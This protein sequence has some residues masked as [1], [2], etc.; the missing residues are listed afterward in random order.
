MYDGAY[1]DWFVWRM[2]FL[3]LQQV[4]VNGPEEWVL[5][6]WVGLFHA[7]ETLSGVSLQQLSQQKR[8]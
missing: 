6:D 3:A 8:G 1:H 5:S 4:P 7:A 2:Q